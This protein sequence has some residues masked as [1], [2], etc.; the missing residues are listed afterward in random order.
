MQM[1]HRIQ[2]DEKFLD[3][4]IFSDESTFHVSGKV[5]SRYIVCIT[6]RLRAG[7]PRN[8]SLIPG[9]GEKF[10]SSS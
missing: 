3:S 1:F 9:R 7:R 2:D 8:R 5:N 6:T 10:L 4:V